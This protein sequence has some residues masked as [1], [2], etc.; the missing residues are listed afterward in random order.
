MNHH[1]HHHQYRSSTI[2]YLIL[3]AGLL[4]HSSSYSTNNKLS[5]F[6][7]KLQRKSSSSSGSTARNS[8]YPTL[9]LKRTR[10]FTFTIVLLSLAALTEANKEIMDSNVA[11]VR[12]NLQR[13]QNVLCKSLL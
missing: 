10:G 6:Q 12:F 4:Q 3:L 2:L 5:E 11:V 13:Q 1:H 8:S 9:H 7:E